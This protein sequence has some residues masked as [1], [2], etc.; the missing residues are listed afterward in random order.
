MLLNTELRDSEK[1]F[2]SLIG[3]ETKASLPITCQKATQE[4]LVGRVD[5][6]YLRSHG[7]ADFSVFAAR[8]TGNLASKA[9]RA[10]EAI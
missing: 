2:K 6:V 7:K 8:V 4:T 9:A 10:S 3:L 1:T 5:T